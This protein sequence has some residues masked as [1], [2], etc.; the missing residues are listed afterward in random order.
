LREKTKGELVRLLRETQTA[1][2]NLRLDRRAGA[3]DDG[4]AIAK[5]RKEV[6]QISTVLAE[7]RIL[8]E[9][10]KSNGRRDDSHKGEGGRD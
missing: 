3:L 9:A 5:K 8:Q 10:G 6:A 2:I 4:S 7:K 1:L